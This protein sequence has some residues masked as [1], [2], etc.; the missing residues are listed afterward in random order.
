M[1]R[2]GKKPIEIPSKVQLN[3]DEDVLRV[4]GPKGEMK[5]DM[6]KGIEYKIENNVLTFSRNGDTKELRALHGLVRS[7]VFNAIE[8][9]SKGVKK[10]LRIEGV[11][12]KAEMKGK[13]L[14]LSIGFSHPVLIIPPEGIEFSSPNATT[15]EVSGYDKHLVGETAAVIRKLRKP[16]PYKGKGIRYDGEYIRRKAGK[17]AG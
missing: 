4:K 6:P 3:F 2:I 11:G 12:Y 13:N 10:V 15:I 17:T 5:I 7:L 9:V 14:V 16:E 1:S 8:G